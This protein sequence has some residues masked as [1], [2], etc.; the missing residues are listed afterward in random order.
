MVGGKKKH[1]AALEVHVMAQG[2]CVHGYFDM[3]AVKR[4]TRLAATAGQ[5]AS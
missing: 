3:D 2:P 1:T 5:Q 4:I